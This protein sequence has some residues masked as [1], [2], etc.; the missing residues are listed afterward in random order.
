MTATPHEDER[1]CLACGCILASDE[2]RGACFCSPCLF[3]R[4]DYDPACDPD[5]DS[6]LE[7]F[8]LSHSA[9]IVSPWRMLG[10]PA[11]FRKSVESSIRRLRRRRL[12]IV[13]VRLPG[14]YVC[15]GTKPAAPR[16]QGRP[17]LRA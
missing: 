4:R 13:G 2:H 11:R 8:F 5:F 3:G 15:L 10:V 14:G 1:R 12:L 16:R 17:R 9:T 7:R 6:I